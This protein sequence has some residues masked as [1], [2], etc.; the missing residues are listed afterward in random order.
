MGMLTLLQYN[1]YIIL[2]GYTTLM[3]C[4]NFNHASTKLSCFLVNHCPTTYQRDSS[5]CDIG[6]I[7]LREVFPSFLTKCI[8][9]LF[10]TVY[11]INISI[12]SYRYYDLTFLYTKVSA[13]FSFRRRDILK[14]R[15][16]IRH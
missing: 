1:L 12:E 15:W 6:C 2:F 14:L 5:M 9:C 16:R 7:V 3:T 8:M 13:P 4:V 11:G 10:I